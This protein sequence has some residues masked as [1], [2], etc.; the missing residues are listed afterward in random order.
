M[1]AIYGGIN[2]KGLV[3]RE[4]FSIKNSTLPKTTQIPALNTSTDDKD[5]FTELLDFSSS[6]SSNPIPIT[7]TS[8]TSATT[9]DELA[10]RKIMHPETETSSAV[11]AYPT[12]TRSSMEDFMNGNNKPGV[13]T[14]SSSDMNVEAIS[15]RHGRR[16]SIKR[17]RDTEIQILSTHV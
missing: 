10:T 17:P 2:P 15:V 6:Q 4:T 13:K 16:R 14:H 1:V 12:T 5:N 8:S 11:P 9:T 3:L 7:I